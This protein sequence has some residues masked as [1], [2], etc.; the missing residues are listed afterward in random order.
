MAIVCLS[1]Y[2]GAGKTTLARELAAKLSYGYFYA[3]GIFRE[4]ANERNL[5]IEAFYDAIQADP[6]LERSVDARSQKLMQERDNIIVEGRIA[7][8]QRTPFKRINILLTVS[9]REGARRQLLRPE[10]STKSIEEMEELTDE[11]IENERKRYWALYGIED[12]FD[13]EKFDIVLDTTRSSIQE[14]LAAMLR[15]IEKRLP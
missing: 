7:P 15:E 11:R 14:A 5:S 1:G 9:G 2:P 10:N 12:H 4:M 3:G 13:P 6:Q 8:F